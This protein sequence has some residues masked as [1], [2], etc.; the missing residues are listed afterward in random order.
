MSASHR[1]FQQR[2]KGTYP[3]R[4]I[5]NLTYH[6][7]IASHR[8]VGEAWD[9]VINQ[10][11]AGEI[12]HRQYVPLRDLGTEKIIWQYWGQ[13]I[14]REKLPEVVQICFESVDKYAGDFKVIRLTDENIADYLSIP[15][16]ILDK[17]DS[18][19]MKKVFFSDLLRV[20]LL[21]SYG[22]IWLDATILM[23]GSFPREFMQGDHFCYQRD[24]QEPYKRIWENAFIYYYC[25]RD[26]FQVRMLRSILWAKKGSEMMT[27]LSDLLLHYWLHDEKS[28]EYF[29][30]QILYNRL[31]TG[32]YQRL[33]PI[34]I[35]DCTPHLLHAVILGT[36]LPY[37]SQDALSKSNLHKLSYFKK[38]EL[39]RLREIVRQLESS[40]AEE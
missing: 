33:K 23:T 17:R 2:I 27:L 30:F 38:G 3:L 1:R 29:F 35:S 25:W 39:Q 13:G 7:L 21:A 12:E 37:S 31:I 6:R 19:L 15:K 40:S 16:E 4:L 34:V 32:A 10:Y 5:N 9:K 24:D 18:G 26:K 22:G 36:L 28:K 11:I 8:R 14:S 20:M